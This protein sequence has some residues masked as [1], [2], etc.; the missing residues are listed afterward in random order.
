MVLLLIAKVQHDITKS[1]NRGILVLRHFQVFGL[2]V[3]L[4]GR[5]SLSTS[6]SQFIVCT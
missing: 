6:E 2:L 5:F 1:L 4:I 3:I